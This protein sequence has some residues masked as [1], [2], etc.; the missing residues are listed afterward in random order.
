MLENRKGQ[1]DVIKI[2]QNNEAI[3]L[4]HAQPDRQLRLIPLTGDEVQEAI[5]SG[6]QEL[7]FSTRE[8]ETPRPPTP[9]ADQADPPQTE[10]PQAQQDTTDQGGG[11]G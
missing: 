1:R 6:R 8:S 9:Q 4:L 3:Q 10:E 11:C 5:T 2:M 7:L